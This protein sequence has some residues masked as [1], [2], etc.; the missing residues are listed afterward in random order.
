MSHFTTISIYVNVISTEWIL[1]F[2]P[3]HL[4]KIIKINIL[5]ILFY[6]VEVAKNLENKTYIEKNLCYINQY[7]KHNH[8]ILK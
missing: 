2:E 7:K 3:S 6:N 8:F 4:I 5:V 1:S